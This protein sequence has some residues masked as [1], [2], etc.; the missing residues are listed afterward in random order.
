VSHSEMGATATWGDAFFTAAS[1]VTVTGLVV[2]DSG[3]TWSAFGELVIL[4]LIQI[5]GLGIMTLAGF[6]GIV[7][8]RRL[9]IRGR[10]LAGTEI[11]LTELGTLRNLIRDLVIFVVISEF[12]IALLLTIRFALEGGRGILRSTYLGVFH[13]V[14]AFNN[15]GFSTLDGGLERYPGDWFMSLVVAGAFIVGGIGFPVVF[16]LRRVWRRPRTWSLHTKVTLATTA[17]LLFGGTLMLAVVEWNN[18]ATIGAAPIGDKI[19][20][21]FFQSATSRTAGFNTVPIGELRTPSLLI[22]LLLMV[23]GASSSS[24][25]GGIKTS[26]FAVV[27]RAT[28]AHLRGDPEVT[29]FS[30]RIPKD[31]ERQAL[32]L[33]IATL[34]AIGT[35]GFL[36]TWFEPELPA[37]ELLFEAASAFG[38]VGVSTGLTAELSTPSRVVIILLMFVG[39]VG[40]ITF[41]TAVLLRPQQQ[42]YG[43]ATEGLIVG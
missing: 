16:E 37:V 28:I 14:S 20:A 38:T 29:I 5:G 36:L 13:A 35:A 25:G 21:S 34:G 19:L 30:R 10:V 1:A 39:R 24:T 40:P 26:T 8:T 27:I 33:V 9:G 6:L 11:G 4:G 41:G 17:L 3:P 31:L 15:A 12:V 2:V 23:I 18:D 43:Y 32:S 7:F 42:R 22:F